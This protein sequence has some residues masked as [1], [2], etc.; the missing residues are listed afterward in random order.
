MITKTIE[1]PLF[2]DKINIVVT[3][4]ISK[5]A[6]EYNLS[7]GDGVDGV[8]WAD[9]GEIYIGITKKATPGLIAHEALHAV[10]FIFEGV[11]IKMDIS[12]DEHQCY[13]LQFIVDEVYKTIKQK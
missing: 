9:K 11:N 3:K 12:N 1:T 2:N 13:L 8:C 6:K 4:K 10:G 7:I 5:I